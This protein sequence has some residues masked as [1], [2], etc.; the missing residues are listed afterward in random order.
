MNVSAST[1]H[2]IRST[3]ITDITEVNFRQLKSEWKSIDLIL[4]DNKI[5]PKFHYH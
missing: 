4:Q 3:L 5:T 2:H 1:F